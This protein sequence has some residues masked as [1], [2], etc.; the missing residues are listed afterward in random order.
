[1]LLFCGDFYPPGE[2]KVLSQSPQNKVPHQEAVEELMDEEPQHADDDVGHVVEEEHV[3]DH[4][5]V[6]SRE[7][8]LVPHEAHQEHQLVQ[9]LDNRTTGSSHCYT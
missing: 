6:A 2:V 8:A 9:E 3:H 5:S 7:R 1:M 4:G